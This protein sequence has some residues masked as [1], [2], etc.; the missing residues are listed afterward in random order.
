MAD[1]TEPRGWQT[2]ECHMAA[3]ST[4]GTLAVVILTLCFRVPQDDAQAL[5]HG[6][7]GALV[8]IAGVV[9]QAVVVWRYIESR[10]ALKAAAATAK[11]RD[12]FL[13]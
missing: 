3:L 5:V 11:E 8:A 7:G 1:R 2:S 9:T 4:L 10:H 6:L 12:P 13:P